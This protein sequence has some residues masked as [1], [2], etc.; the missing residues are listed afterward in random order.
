[1]LRLINILKN[2]CG[3]EKKE[4][5]EK[6]PHP[7]IDD[8][9]LSCDFK[10]W[11]EFNKEMLIR[12]WIKSSRQFVDKDMI[13]KSESPEYQFGNN[14]ER[15]MAEEALNELIEFGYLNPISYLREEKVNG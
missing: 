1:M 8:Y 14:S 10:L 3:Y 9:G 5:T 6:N 15:K 7:E 4:V 2:L 11:S 12:N 13:P